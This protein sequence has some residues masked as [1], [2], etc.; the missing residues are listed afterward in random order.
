MAQ[1]NDIEILRQRAAEDLLSAEILL[2]S[3]RELLGQVGFHLQ[4][5][6]EKKM[7]ASLQEHKIKYPLTHDLAMLM[8][9]FP[10]KNIAE[11]D[12]IF[13]YTL[14]QFAVESRYGEQCASPWDGWQ[15]LEKS[16]EFTEMIEALWNIQ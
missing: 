5:Y 12:K 2:N 8:K 9:L 11:E 4:Q 14:S 1:Y 13:A 7:K 10:Q 16:K 3:N 6:I 15:M